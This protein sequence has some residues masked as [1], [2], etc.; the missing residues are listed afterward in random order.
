M[1]FP[2][3][4]KDRR[5]EAKLTTLGIFAFNA[6]SNRRTSRPMKSI[7]FA[8][9]HYDGMAKGRVPLLRLT[10]DQEGDIQR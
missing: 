4:G 10:H 1:R 5:L 7:T 3:E 8:Y 2:R 6:E 9:R